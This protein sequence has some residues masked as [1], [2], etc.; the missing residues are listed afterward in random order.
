M[1]LDYFMNVKLTYTFPWSPV[2][3]NLTEATTKCAYY[4]S[5]EH[6]PS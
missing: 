1:I 2:V 3:A 6:C 4:G 5:T